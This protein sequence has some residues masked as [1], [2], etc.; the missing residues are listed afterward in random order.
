MLG[1]VKRTSVL[2]N[3]TTKQITLKTQEDRIVVSTEDQESISSGSETIQCEYNE[4]EIVIAFNS[5]YLKEVLSH[6]KT[7]KVT[8]LLKNSL[9]ASI[10]LPGKDLN[11]TNSSKT[12]LLMPIRINTHDV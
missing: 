11:I 10:F 2:S 8:I 5:N 7:D 1:A 6:I 4:E 9:S 3:K 12:T